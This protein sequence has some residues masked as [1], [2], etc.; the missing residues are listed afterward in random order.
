MNANDGETLSLV[1]LYQA[2]L[3]DKTKALE[4]IQ[5]ARGLAPGSRKVQ[6]EAALIYELAGQRDRA[7][8]ALQAA[9]RAG[10]PLDEVRGEPA[11]AKLRADPRYQQMVASK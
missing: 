3:G 11:L 8:D 7:L 6:W 4:N 9:I 10:Q 5:K 1:A 2:K